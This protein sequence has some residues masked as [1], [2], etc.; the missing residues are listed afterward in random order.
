MP[1]AMTKVGAVRPCP[2]RGTGPRRPSPR[3]RLAARLAS[4]G[5]AVG[6]VG[7]GATPAW[8][9]S[10]AAWKAYDQTA[11]SACLKASRLLQ[12]RLLGERIDVPVAEPSPSGITPLISAFLI[13]GVY[14]QAHPRG[15]R[16]RELCLFEQRTGRATVAEAE[17]LDRPRRKP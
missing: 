16:G 14:P 1:C 17:A 10:P 4:I 11:R 6:L 2:A 8:P 5:V 9:S 7:L 15:Q 13:E 12:P 3:Q